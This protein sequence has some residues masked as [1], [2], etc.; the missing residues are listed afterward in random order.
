MIQIHTKP[1]LTINIR[2]VLCFCFDER[3]IFFMFFTVIW[4]KTKLN[5]YPVQ[6]LVFVVR[7][8]WIDMVIEFNSDCDGNSHF[9]Q[10]KPKLIL[11]WETHYDF[12]ASTYFTLKS[13]CLFL[14][15]DFDQVFSVPHVSFSYD[16]TSFQF[17]N[18]SSSVFF[19]LLHQ[20]MFQFL[21]SMFNVHSTKVPSLNNINN[22]KKRK[23]K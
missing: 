23:K 22:E 4:E 9:V 8:T 6:W 20:P 17:W 2:S 5:V 21:C 11:K 14:E 16:F 3:S 10:R 19:M 15:I 1:K 7:R 18:I 12:I 13:C